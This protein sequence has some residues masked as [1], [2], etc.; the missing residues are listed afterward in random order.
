MTKQ[1]QTKASYT[2]WNISL[3]SYSWIFYVYKICFKGGKQGTYSA[4]YFFKASIYWLGKV[5]I[6]TNIPGPNLAEIHQNE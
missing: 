5:N 1:S 2:H 4:K 3:S 6:L